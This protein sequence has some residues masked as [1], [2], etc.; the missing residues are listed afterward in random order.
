MNFRWTIRFPPDY[1]EEYV[2]TSLE[3]M[4]VAKLD[5]M[6]FHIWEDHWLDD[7]RLLKA[8]DKMRT[9]AQCARWGSV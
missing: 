9:R 5:L 3:N 6:Q 4:G 1:I 8:I 2:H 7:D